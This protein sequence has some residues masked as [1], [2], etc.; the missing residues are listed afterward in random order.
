MTGGMKSIPGLV[1]W[2]DSWETASQERLLHK[3]QLQIPCRELTPFRR[4]ENENPM[5]R[6]FT[7]ALLLLVV[8][9]C[10]E[11]HNNLPT[12]KCTSHRIKYAC[13]H[14]R[15]LGGL[16]D[17]LKKIHKTKDAL[18]FRR[19]PLFSCAPC[20]H[21]VKVSHARVASLFDC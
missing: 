16:N 14:I 8:A 17:N 9:T 1:K 3:E 4:D 19:L 15:Q 2:H 12:I 10:V 18:L 6:Y 11:R 21:K 5:S 7:H 20:S 13:L